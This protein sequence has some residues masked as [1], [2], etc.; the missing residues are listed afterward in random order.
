MGDMIEEW[1]ATIG[2]WIGGRARKCV[3]LQSAL[4]KRLTISVQGNQIRSAGFATGHRL[5]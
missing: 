4:F 1:R 5:R 3:I 2:L